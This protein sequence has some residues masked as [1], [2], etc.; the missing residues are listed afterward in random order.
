MS[1]SEIIKN[2]SPSRRSQPHDGSQR[3]AAVLALFDEHHGDLRLWFIR[4]AELGDDHSGQVAFPGGHL[5]D[6]ETP[7][8][9]A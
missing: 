8:I 1:L 3:R 2:L 4:R 6:H 7:Q 9:R 5:H